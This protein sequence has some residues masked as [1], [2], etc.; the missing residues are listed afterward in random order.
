MT[1]DH[2]RIGAHVPRGPRVLL[3]VWRSAVGRHKDVG[4]AEFSMQR[5]RD[6]VVAGRREQLV[7]RDRVARCLRVG[8]EPMDGHA[9]DKHRQPPRRRLE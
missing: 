9:V 4:V 1:I 6:V 3:L 7:V 8:E 2:E 5:E